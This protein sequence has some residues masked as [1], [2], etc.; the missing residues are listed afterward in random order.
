M[1]I[2][3]SFILLPLRREL[4]TELLQWSLA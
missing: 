3:F 1:Y 4:D 2:I